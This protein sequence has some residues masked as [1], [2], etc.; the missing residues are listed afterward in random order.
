VKNITLEMQNQ[1]KK[2]NTKNYSWTLKKIGGRFQHG[3]EREE[4]ESEPPIVKPWR[5][6]GDTLCR[7]NFDSST[8]P[9]GAENLHFTLNGETRRVP[10]PP[11]TR[12]QMVWE[13]VDKVSFT[14]LQYS[15][16]QPWARGA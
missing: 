10:G 16:R 8:P 3:G 5:D 1:E 7:P 2:N 4:A 13:D 15:H 12:A 11:V 9:A 14:V 6:T